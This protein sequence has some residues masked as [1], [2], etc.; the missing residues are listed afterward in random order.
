MIF[1]AHVRSVCGADTQVTQ[2]HSLR[3]RLTDVTLVTAKAASNHPRH[4]A[5]TCSQTS[6]RSLPLKPPVAAASAAL[7]A[8]ARWCAYCCRMASRQAS[9]GSPKW[10]ERSN[11][12]AR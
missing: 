9:S 4:P 2:S 6:R 8:G 5:P 1:D 10:M 7:S 3:Q 11:L 12:T